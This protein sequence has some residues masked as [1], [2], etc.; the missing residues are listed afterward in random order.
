MVKCTQ[1]CALNACSQVCDIAVNYHMQLMSLALQYDSTCNWIHVQI[2]VCNQSYWYCSELC[3]TGCQVCM[4]NW[5]PGIHVQL[6]AKYAC[7]TGCQNSCHKIALPV[8]LLQIA[9]SEQL[10]QIALPV[11]LLQIALSVQLPEI[12]LP[13]QLLQIALPEQLPQIALPVQ[14]LQIA[15]I[16]ELQRIA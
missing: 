2:T 15:C 11:Q 5:L 16:Q 8:Q 7:A 9:L 6:V 4:C 3:A 13:V 1:V 12:A 14:L 10:P